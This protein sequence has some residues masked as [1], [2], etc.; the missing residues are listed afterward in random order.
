VDRITSVAS[1]F[2]SRVD[3]K[4][5]AQLPPDFPLR[6]DVAIANAIRAHGVYLQRFSDERWR[7]LLQAGARPQRPLWASTGTKDPPT[8]TYSTSSV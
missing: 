8:P 5:D 6:G 4:A 2:V 7:A 3:T 1:F